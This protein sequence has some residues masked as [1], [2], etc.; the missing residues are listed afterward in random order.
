MRNKFVIEAKKSLNNDRYA[1]NFDIVKLLAMTT[2]LGYKYGFYLALP[3]GNDFTALGE[4]GIKYQRL[5][6]N[7]SIYK[8]MIKRL[9]R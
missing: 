2:Q 9:K 8:I 4:F 5:F 7:Y 1:K 3:C 6:E